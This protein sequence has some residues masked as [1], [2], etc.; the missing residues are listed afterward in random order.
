MLFLGGPA[1]VERKRR[2]N[3]GPGDDGL[4]TGA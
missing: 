1:L 2:A 4:I 3:G